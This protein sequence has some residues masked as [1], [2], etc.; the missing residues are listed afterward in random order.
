MVIFHHVADSQ[1][2]YH[3]VV[4][5]FCIGLGRL[6]MMIAALPIDLEMRFRDVLGGFAAALTA[7]LAPAH[8]TLFTSENALGGAIETRVCH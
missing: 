1:V 5:A 2:F 8:R 6:E 4:I 7:L 3:N